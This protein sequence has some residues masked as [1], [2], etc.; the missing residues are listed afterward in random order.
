MPGRDVA[1]SRSTGT[2]P[3]SLTSARLAAAVVV[4]TGMTVPVPSDGQAG[5]GSAMRVHLGPVE[6][7]LGVLEGDLDQEFGDLTAVLARPAA[8]VLLLDSRT[9]QL[10]LFD[11][12]GRFRGRLGRSGSG[13]GEFRV[14]T[15]VD[16]LGADTLAVLDYGLSRI[17]LAVW[18]GSVAFAGSFR[19]AAPAFDLCSIGPAVFVSGA[20]VGD[21]SIVRRIAVPG[22]SV[23]PIGSLFAL[24]RQ[25]PVLAGALSLRLQMECVPQLDLVVV[26]SEWLPE[27]RAY[28]AGSGALR[29]SASLPDFNATIVTHTA[30]GRISF[31]PP[32]TAVYHMVTN[33]RR[34]DGTL[35]AVQ[36]RRRIPGQARALRREVVETR[37]LDAGTGRQVGVQEDLPVIL[38]ADSGLLFLADTTDYPRLVVRRYEVRPEA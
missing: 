38:R 12:T 18:T 6:L 2:R 9:S 26:A 5:A 35:L 32:P 23:R 19:V 29:W 10:R 7:A 34:L 21:S 27:V 1:R 24:D 14:P 28:A 8:G 11:W 30:D 31:K 13:P 4:A 20:R 36:V 37:L 3:A 33:L 16:W 25:D 15:A 22:G 17:T